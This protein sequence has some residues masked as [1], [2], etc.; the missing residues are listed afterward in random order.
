MLSRTSSSNAAIGPGLPSIFGAVTLAMSLAIVIACCQQANAS[1]GNVR[2]SSRLVEP[3]NQNP[4]SLAN[5]LSQN[6]NQPTVVH[7]PRSRIEQAMNDRNTV[8]KG[9]VESAA[10]VTPT[11]SQPSST[12][13]PSS[14]RSQVNG[15]EQASYA[16][17][18]AD[19]SPT[20]NAMASRRLENGAEKGSGLALRPPTEKGAAAPTAKRSSVAS[21]LSMMA[22]LAVVI[23]L[24]LV[25]AWG[26]KRGASKASPMLPKEVVQVLGR[27]QMS[28]RQQLYVLR[29]GNRLVLVSQ[30]PGQTE[31]LCE[32]DDPLEVDR[33]S[34]LCEQHSPNSVTQSFRQVF[35]QVTSGNPGKLRADLRG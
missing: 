17:P 3:A 28:T 7:Q 1:A 32:I 13:A 9:M 22:S 4:N 5:G 30:Q 19:G 15:N 11:A 34:G 27:S 33:I 14:G 16:V 6:T 23:G 10:W 2:P 18:L 24:F 29:F 12:N 8:S 31:T 20:A 26:M 21:F 35:Q 25:V